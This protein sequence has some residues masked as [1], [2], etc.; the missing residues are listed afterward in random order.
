MLSCDRARPISFSL[1]VN[2]FLENKLAVEK[3]DGI[4]KGLPLSKHSIRKYG[5]TEHIKVQ[6][7]LKKKELVVVLVP[8]H[9]RI[10][11][12]ALDALYG[13]EGIQIYFAIRACMHWYKTTACTRIHVLH[14]IN[15]I[16]YFTCMGFAELWQKRGDLTQSYDKSPYTNRNVKRAKRQHKQRH[17]KVRLNSSCGPT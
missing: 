5:P 3:A 9:S 8:I 4:L 7:L 16:L 2:V 15:I 13:F 14:R 6:D 12:N 17:K 1:S 10:E 11:E